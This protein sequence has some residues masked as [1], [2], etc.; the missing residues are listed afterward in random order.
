MLFTDRSLLQGNPRACLVGY[1]GEL[2]HTNL[3]QA[4]LCSTRHNH[5]RNKNTMSATQTATV[6]RP[7]ADSGR[8]LQL[9]SRLTSLSFL[10][11][12]NR[13]DFLSSPISPS[14]QT[15]HKT[16]ASE[17]SQTVIA[18]IGVQYKTRPS[19]NPPTQIQLNQFLGGARATTHPTSV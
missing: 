16:P 15:N 7:A 18:L 11:Y 12:P 19:P 14:Q 13:P 2:A 4:S 3:N 8:P 10:N 5:Q 1:R 9:N 17:F 6:E